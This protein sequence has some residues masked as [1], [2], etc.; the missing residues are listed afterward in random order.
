M[1]NCTAA[2]ALHDVLQTQKCELG[3]GCG[4]VVVEKL[5]V[6]LGWVRVRYMRAGAM[7]IDLM[8]VGRPPV[9]DYVW[10]KARLMR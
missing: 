9:Q 8:L 5:G 2:I 1:P 4:L 10:L 7:C 3:I 6:W